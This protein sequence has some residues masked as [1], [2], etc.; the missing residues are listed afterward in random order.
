[1]LNDFDHRLCVICSEHYC[2]SE[3]NYLLIMQPVS[4]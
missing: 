1:V 3:N 4:Q 2:V